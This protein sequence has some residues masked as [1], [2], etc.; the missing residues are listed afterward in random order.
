[1]SNPPGMMTWGATCGRWWSTEWMEPGSLSPCLEEACP[2][3]RDQCE[4][5]WARDT[6]PSSLRHYILL[7]VFVATVRNSYLLIICQIF[8]NSSTWLTLGKNIIPLKHRVFILFCGDKLFITG[9]DFEFTYPKHV[10]HSKQGE[11]LSCSACSLIGHLGPKLPEN[12]L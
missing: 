9:T 4:L 2:L 3:V 7:D 5:R 10:N 11:H 1:M 12:I 8:S 6:L